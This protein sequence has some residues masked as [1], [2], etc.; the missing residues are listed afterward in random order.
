[1]ADDFTQDVARTF[2][3]KVSKPLFN[4]TQPV[5]SVNESAEIAEPLSLTETL[6]I[7]DVA[8]VLRREREQAK[9][10][11]DAGQVQDQLRQRLQAAAEVTGEAVTPAEIDAAIRHYYSNLHA[12]HEPPRSASWFLAHLYIRRVWVG[13][14]VLAAALGLA[15]WMLW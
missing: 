1:M 11:L 6:R 9:R 7:M 2:H 4:R 5:P 15:A 12:F 14:G 10:A 8:S 13:L 3:R